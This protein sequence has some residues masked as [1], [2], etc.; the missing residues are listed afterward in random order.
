MQKKFIWFA[1]F[2]VLAIPRIF[3]HA[4]FCPS[5]RRELPENTL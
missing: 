5:F 1:K 4:A 3:A 2:Y